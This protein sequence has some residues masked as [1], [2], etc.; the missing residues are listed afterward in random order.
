MDYLLGLKSL[1]FLFSETEVSS[2]CSHINEDI[3]LWDEIHDVMHHLRAYGGM[4]SI[5]DVVIC[6][7]N[8]HR[9]EKH[10]E[11][12]ANA[13]LQ[14]LLSW[15]SYSARCIQDG[16]APSLFTVEKA[17]IRNPRKIQGRRCLQCG[18][19]ELTKNNND[20]F[21]APVIV[22]KRLRVIS[23]EHEMYETINKLLC[24]N[25]SEIDILRKRLIHAEEKSGI[26]YKNSEWMR[27][28]SNCKSDD[29]AVYRW[30]LVGNIFDNSCCKMISSTDNLPLRSKK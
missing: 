22:E 16:K 2:W 27:I 23:D 19:A 9:I 25:D 26:H 12:W 7:Q 10:Q 1:A 6:V 8:G 3:R 13:L 28:C 20:N 30:D 14:F 15:C 5:N 24:A 4:G 29:I 11:P 21:I 17:N 18:Y